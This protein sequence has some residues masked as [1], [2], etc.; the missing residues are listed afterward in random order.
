MLNN[1]KELLYQTGSLSTDYVQLFRQERRNYLTGV[2][3]EL[4]CLVI[5]QCL[6]V[7]TRGSL[8]AKH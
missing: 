6:H 8:R 2:A 5:G 7:A 1:M 3:P 4:D